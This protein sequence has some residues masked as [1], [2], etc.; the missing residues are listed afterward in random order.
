M[1]ASLPPVPA[2][3]PSGLSSPEPSTPDNN[4]SGLQWAYD[5]GA[6]CNMAI[7]QRK[8]VLV[9][10]VAKGNRDVAQY[11][12][13]YFTVPAVRSIMDQFIVVKIDFPQN[14]RLGY[15]LGIYGAGM[16]SITDAS[17][18]RVGKIEQIPATPEEFAK[19][20]SAFK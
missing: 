13:N 16:I 4:P 14:T 7:Q 8:K 12:N 11:E 17:G 6:A 1:S 15:A 5:F 2:A 9:F 20:I 19:M 10:F 18:S 3:G